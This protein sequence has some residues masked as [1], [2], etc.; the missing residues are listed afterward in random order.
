M[1]VLTEETTESMPDANE[2]ISNAN[3]EYAGL[4]SEE[5]AREDAFMAGIPR[6][7][8]AA[9]LMPPIWGPAH[10]IWLTILY[11]PIWLFVDNCLYAAY[12][13]PIAW[14]IILAAVVA[15]TLALATYIFAMVAGPM[16][17]HRAAAMGVDKDVY[18]RRQ[19]IWAVVCV[20]LAVL[21]LGFATYYNLALRGAAA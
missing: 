9:F 6:F 17:A 3:S 21:F 20:I 2:D 13:D 16:S 11:Y 8:L 19:R 7:N 5:V 10:G 1:E 14:K 18:I 12:E 4:T 15:V